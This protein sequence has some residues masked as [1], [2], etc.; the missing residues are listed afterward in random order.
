MNSDSAPRIVVGLSGGVDSSVAAALLKEEGW[1]VIGIMLRLW[2]DAGTLNRCCPPDAVIEA[3][4]IAQ[5]LDIPFYVVD[6]KQAFY[7]AVVEPF[8]AGYA[9]GLTPNPCLR[10]NRLIRW[11]FLR[12][13]AKALNADKI[14]TGHYARTKLLPN[15]I[16]Q[17]LKNPDTEK[18][19]SYFL[20]LLTQ[21]DLL[22]TVFPLAEL[23][24]AEVRKLAR[25]FSLPVADRPDSQDLCFVGQGDYR[26]FLRKSLPNA[27]RPGPILNQDGEQ[28]GE[29]TGLSDYTIGQRKGLGIA[30]PEPYYVI[31]KDIEN[32]AL[33]VGIKTELGRT[34]FYTHTTNWI[35]GSVSAEP[36][37][38]EIKIRYKSRP[39][40]GLVTPLPDHQAGIILEEPAPDITPGQAGVFYQGQICLGG[41]TISLEES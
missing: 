10:C 39:I 18:D 32:N 8:I 6:A 4:N 31:Q 7:D 25:E 21:D 15:G 34:K 16:V 5:Q 14:A 26:D 22:G 33:V 40:P 20:H 30:G 28:L 37:P 36:F 13:R 9:S 38:A 41:G 1:Q 17:L 29:H 24:K 12:S 3:R 23:S 19:Q 27:L 11:S 2:S 35:A